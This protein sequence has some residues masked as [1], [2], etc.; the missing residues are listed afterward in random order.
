MLREG[1]REKH[2]PCKVTHFYFVLFHYTSHHFHSPFSSFLFLLAI[3]FVRRMQLKRDV[4]SQAFCPSVAQIATVCTLLPLPHPAP[5]SRLCPPSYAVFFCGCRCAWHLAKV[6]TELIATAE[7][8][9]S[10]SKGKARGER[11]RRRAWR[12]SYYANILI[13]IIPKSYTT[14]WS[15]RGRG[16]REWNQVADEDD[17]D[18]DDE[19]EDDVD[20]G[21]DEDVKHD[22]DDE[23]DDYGSLGACRLFSGAFPSLPKSIFHTLWIL[24]SFK[25]I[26]NFFLF[27]CAAHFVVQCK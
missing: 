10:S 11:R 2:S 13:N 16:W 3:C 14:T 21:G 12:K 20:V 5:C 25:K 1:E 4:K 19:G 22:V 9:A 15:W 8:F 6:G 7:P 24:N 17:D 27:P 23:H 26:W 18:E